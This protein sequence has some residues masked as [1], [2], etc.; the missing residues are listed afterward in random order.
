MISGAD[1]VWVVY[2]PRLL[3]EDVFKETNFRRGG[4]VVW[5]S[6]LL[7]S[8]RFTAKAIR[9]IE[10]K[11]KVAIIIDKV[12]RQIRFQGPTQ[13]AE[14][15]QRILSG[16]LGRYFKEDAARCEVESSSGTSAQEDQSCSEA[17][18]PIC[19]CPA[20]NAIRTSCRHFHCL[21]CFQNCCLSAASTSR[22]KFEVK[23]QGNGGTCLETF[24][25]TELNEHLSSSVGPSDSMSM[26]DK[27][28]RSS[29]KQHIVRCPESFRYCPT[30]D[31]GNIYRCTT[32]QLEQFEQGLTDSKPPGFTCSNCLVPRCTS[33]HENPHGQYTCA[34]NKEMVESEAL[35][36]LKRK[37][38]IKDCPKCSTPMEKVMGCNHMICGG[39]KTHI[40]WECMAVFETGGPCYEHMNEVHG[41]HGGDPF[42][43]PE[44]GAAINMNDPDDVDALLAVADEPVAA[45]NWHWD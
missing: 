17:E 5:D 26:F 9:G 32:K 31:C 40:C 4:K 43:I 39:C 30:P 21:E 41:G 24:T 7:G 45:G 35:R 3:E 15:V 33:C 1:R 14:H 34:E 27:V 18:C 16:L 10:Q 19:F 20:E 6:A 22:S 13:K 12:K 23:C 29:L 2:T 36:G 38:N 37:L 11:V 28:L 8:K 42:I 44:D 25:L